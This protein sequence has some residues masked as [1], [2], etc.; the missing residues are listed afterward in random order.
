MLARSGTLPRA[1]SKI[2][3]SVPYLGSVQTKARYLIWYFACFLISRDGL[4]DGASG[5]ASMR[6]SIVMEERKQS[7]QQPSA[8]DPLFPRYLHYLP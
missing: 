1:R 8:Y 7:G 2:R 3:E 6:S 5:C 4:T